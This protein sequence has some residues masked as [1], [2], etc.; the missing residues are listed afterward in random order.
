[1]DDRTHPGLAAACCPPL[2][3]GRLGTHDRT[4]GVPEIDQARA[5]H[6]LFRFIKKRREASHALCKESSAEQRAGAAITDFKNKARRAAAQHTVFIRFE[7][8]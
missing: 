6:G 3:R 8:R 1:M 2:P 5:R 4:V 7:S